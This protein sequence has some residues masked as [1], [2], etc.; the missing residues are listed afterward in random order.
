MRNATPSLHASLASFA[1]LAP[2]LRAAMMGWTE[3]R[4]AAAASSLLHICLPVNVVVAVRLSICIKSHLE[5]AVARAQGPLT[6]DVHSWRRRR[7]IPKGVN[8]TDKLRECDHHEERGG[9][10]IR[11]FCVCHM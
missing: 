4:K 3:S 9:Q 7:D 6:Y 1:S 11:K 10:S 2:F 5:I 8:C